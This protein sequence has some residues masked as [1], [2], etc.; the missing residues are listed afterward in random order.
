MPR[1]DRLDR[2]ADGSQPRR[3][4]EA[5]D[6]G[7]ARPEVEPRRGVGRLR[8]H[9]VALGDPDVGH[10]RPRPLSQRQIALGGELGVGVDGDA[11]RHPELA[12]E[13]ARGGDLRAGVQRAVADRLAQA[14]FDLGAQRL[15]RIAADVDQ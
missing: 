10:A 15:R 8:R 13:V 14:I 4:R 5:G 3:A 2:L 11:A 1:G 9:L 12:R 6:V 7:H